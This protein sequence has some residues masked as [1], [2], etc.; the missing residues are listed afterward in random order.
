L[1]EYGLHFHS[2]KAGASDEK[3]TDVH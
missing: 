3:S 2:K 1:Q